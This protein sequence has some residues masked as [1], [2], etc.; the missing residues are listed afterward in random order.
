L[1]VSSREIGNRSLDF[2]HPGAAVPAGGQMG[3][4][5][6]GATGLKFAVRR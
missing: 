6:S 4:D 1:A 2:R 5:L 3:A